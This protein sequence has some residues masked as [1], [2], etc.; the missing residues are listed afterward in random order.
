MFAASL[1][2]SAF[3]ADPA[4]PAA[5]PTASSAK[6]EA[7]KTL[8]SKVAP[9]KVAAKKDTGIK[10]S[11]KKLFSPSTKKTDLKLK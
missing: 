11:V 10:A 1:S 5:A 8:A 3:A 7:N 9:S 6:V 4:K 2:A